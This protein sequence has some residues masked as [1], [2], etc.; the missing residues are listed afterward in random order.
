[1]GNDGTPGVP[2]FDLIKLMEDWVLYYPPTG[3]NVRAICGDLFCDK[4]LP[5]WKGPTCSVGVAKA[6]GGSWTSQ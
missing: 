5:S 4:N 6:A 1:M 2:G 3:P